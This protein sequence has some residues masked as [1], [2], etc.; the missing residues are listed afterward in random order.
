[1]KT[2]LNWSAGVSDSRGN[3][4]AKEFLFQSLI[5]RYFRTVSETDDFVKV[6]DRL[7]IDSKKTP[8]SNDSN[9]VE[10]QLDGSVLQLFP[11][12][13]QG[14]DYVVSLCVKHPMSA[15]K[16]FMY[17]DSS[18]KSFTSIPDFEG[19]FTKENTIVDYT[20]WNF[21]CRNNIL[22]MFS[23]GLFVILIVHRDGANTSWGCKLIY[24]DVRQQKRA[25]ISIDGT[26]LPQHYIFRVRMEKRV[27]F[28]GDHKIE[29][30]L[31]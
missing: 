21:D 22:Q 10:I 13:Y 23:D 24:H 29:L 16:S 20:T 25:A 14:G 31:Q 1:M 12:I 11:D 30:R 17:Y 18:K 27:V 8:Y 9:H 5:D 19:C 26:D 28:I 15:A 7:Y 2:T 6:T 3:Q 4:L